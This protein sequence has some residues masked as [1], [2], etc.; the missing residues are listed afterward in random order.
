MKFVFF[1]YDFMI[2]TLERLVDDGHEL[3]GLF[4]FA[5]DNVFNFNTRVKAFALKNNA[6]TVEEK[7]TE[8][9]I[10]R[11]L[12]HGADCFFSA[13]YPYKIPP[14]KEQGVFAINLHP[15]YLPKGRGIMPTPYI[16]MEEPDAAGFTIHKLTD[17]YDAGDIL[18]QERL[19]LNPGEDVES[20]SAR[21]MMRAPDA[22]SVVMKDIEGYWQD[23]SP[24]KAED[25]S[26]FPAPDD[27]MRTLD[28]NGSVHMID[29]TYR[30][31]GR[32]GSLAYFENAVF[33]V[34]QLT[35]WEEDHT[36][37]PGQIACR[38]SRELVVAV[39]DG[40]VCL[41]DFQPVRTM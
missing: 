32:F 34:Y 35:A 5:C 12:E 38:S 37:V 9:H 40:F 18:Y 14:I 27:L 19:P 4:T 28:W 25:V 23:A 36:F 17:E 8:Q 41:K 1:G 30:A 16:I 3:I 21:I 6:P 11:L 20:L 31:F 24:Q 33:V 2:D 7:A 15:A 22:V 13:G 10:A 26:H 29:K 39:T